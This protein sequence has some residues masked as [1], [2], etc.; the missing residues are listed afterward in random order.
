MDFVWY[1]RSWQGCVLIYDRTTVRYRRHDDAHRR[2]TKGRTDL[3]RG[4][5]REGEGRGEKRQGWSQ[6]KVVGNHFNCFAFRSDHL[7]SLS[8]SRLR[9][10]A[11]RFFVAPRMQPIH[12]GDALRRCRRRLST[13]RR[14]ME[15]FGRSARGKELI[16][17]ARRETNVTR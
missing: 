4:R 13:T 8:L 12:Y 16:R 17:H 14:E 1:L 6:R 7:L 11:R 10:A 15:S 9:V 5:G 3:E 2:R